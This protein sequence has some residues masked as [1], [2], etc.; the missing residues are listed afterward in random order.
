MIFNFASVVPVEPPVVYNIVNNA[1]QYVLIDKD[2]AEEG[3]TVTITAIVD[4]M[5]HGLSA[6]YDN[7]EHRL[8][9]EVS[10][11]STYTF[12]MPAM[13]VEIHLY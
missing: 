7:T 13:D 2:T 9:Y 6:Y 4:N 5:H 8:S 3:A 11:G 12:T 10:Q 1:A